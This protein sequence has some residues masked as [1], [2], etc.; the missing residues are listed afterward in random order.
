M[1]KETTMQTPRAYVMVGAPGSGKSTYAAKLAEQEN[2]VVISGDDVRAE[3]YGSADI[4]GNWGEIWE[5]IDELVSECCGMSVILDGT[6]CRKDYRNEAIQLLKSYGYEKVDAV[7]LDSSLAT[8]LAR[9]FQRTRHVP[10]YVIT[11][12]HDNL[13]RSLKTIMEEDFDLIN[14]VY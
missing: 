1:R 5:R 10:D 3:L 7:V 13:Q 2:A 6:H 8:C 9:N 12:M 11:E 14:F 4:L